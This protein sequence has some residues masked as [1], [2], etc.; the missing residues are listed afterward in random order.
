MFATGAARAA[1]A[2]AR[3]PHVALILPL[4]SPSFGRHADAVRQG[5]VAAARV[6]GKDAPPIRVYPV[7]EDTL[8]VLTIYEQAVESGAQLVVGPLT[9]N[10]VAALAAS[11][12]VTVPTLALNSLEPRSPHPARMYLFGLGI[13]FEARQVA[14]IAFE[15]GR[16]NAFVVSDDTPLGKR[17]RQAFLE[18]FARLGGITVAEFSFGAD[19]ISLNKLRHAANLGVADMV[20]LA[21]DFARARTVRPYLGNTLAL[22]ATSQ[23]NAGSAGALAAH[24][25]NLVRFVDMPWLLQSDHPAVMV[26]PR[27]QFGDT[28][29]FDRLYALGIDAFRIGVEL[30]RQNRHSVLDGVT[31]R[32]RLTSEQQFVREL[33]VA[34]FVDGRTVLLG[35]TR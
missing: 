25:L 28:I 8:N 32:I 33:T 26:Y 34:Q 35:E 2:A 5:F 24:D 14:R 11:N 3:E 10:G 27:P 29:D 7:N 30:L 18:E 13:E 1:E 4:G 31:G 20:F 17:M 15:D 19:Q 21:L 12:L 16:R 9:R 23:V 6:A 22:Y